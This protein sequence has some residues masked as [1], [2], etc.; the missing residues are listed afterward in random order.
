MHAD[1]GGGCVDT[2]LSLVNLQNLIFHGKILQKHELAYTISG[3]VGSSNVLM[4]LKLCGITLVI[5]LQVSR[6]IYSRIMVI[7]WSWSNF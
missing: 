1:W 2:F 4:F 6:D 7:I 5:M 3:T